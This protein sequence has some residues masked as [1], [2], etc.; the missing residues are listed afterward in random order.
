[1]RFIQRNGAHLCNDIS[2]LQACLAGG[3]AAGYAGDIDA[4][5]RWQVV[6]ECDIGIDGLETNSEIWACKVALLDDLLGNCLGRIDR[7]GEAQSFGDIT[8]SRVAD[9]QRV[10]ADHLA[11][12]VGQ[13]SAGIAVIDGCV[14]LDQILDLVSVPG[15]NGAPGRTD[16]AHSDRVLKVAQWRANRNHRFTGVQYI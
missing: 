1:M 3:T 16:Y 6:A 15:V 11:C 5:L 7:D 9:N 12:Q 4:P 10:D 14:S 8:T 2:F 13:R